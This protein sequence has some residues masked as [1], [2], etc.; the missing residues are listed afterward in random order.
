M[1]QDLCLASYFQQHPCHSAKYV[2]LILLLVHFSKR[3]FLGHYTFF[4][5]RGNLGA[6]GKVVVM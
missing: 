2:A 1:L 4:L 6:T 5:V 3:I